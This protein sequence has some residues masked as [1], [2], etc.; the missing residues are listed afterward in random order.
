MS[1]SGTKKGRRLACANDS[2]GG[3]NGLKAMWK[4]KEPL[5]R[6]REAHYSSSPFSSL[7]PGTAKTSILADTECLC[8]V[9]VHIR[10]LRSM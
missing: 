1:E 8:C 6:R 2:A 10:T 7:S 9:Y 3:P 5:P 4:W